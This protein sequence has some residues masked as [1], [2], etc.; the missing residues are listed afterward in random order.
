MA[1]SSGIL[2]RVRIRANQLSK[3]S[4]KKKVSEKTGENE[5]SGNLYVSLQRGRTSRGVAQ[6]FELLVAGQG[7]GSNKKRKT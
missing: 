2:P 5:L 6:H 1:K 3:S 4:R 7:G